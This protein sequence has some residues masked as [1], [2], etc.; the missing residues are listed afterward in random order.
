MTELDRVVRKLAEDSAWDMVS[1]YRLKQ[2][3]AC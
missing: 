3:E 2:E 1:L